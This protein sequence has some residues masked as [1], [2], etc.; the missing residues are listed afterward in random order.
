[1]APFLLGSK[2]LFG[3]DIIMLIESPSLPFVRHRI[4]DFPVRVPVNPDQVKTLD[5]AKVIPS[6]KQDLEAQ[7]SDL[8]KTI[9]HFETL[10]QQFI[11]SDANTNHGPDDV[12]NIY[13][14]LLTKAKQAMLTAPD[15]PDFIDIS[16]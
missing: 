1:M 10:S 14:D 15:K 13:R 6:T 4:S 12:L 16:V 2:K 8:Q 3:E 5:R 7:I 9:D 11:R